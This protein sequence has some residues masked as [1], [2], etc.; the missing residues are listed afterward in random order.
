MEMADGSQPVLSQAQLKRELASIAHNIYKIDLQIQALK[1]GQGSQ[2][3]ISI[4]ET[5]KLQIQK[6]VGDKE[7]QLKYVKAQAKKNW[8]Y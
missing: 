2:H 5:A 8:G 6:K 1:R 3:R 7:L 4:L